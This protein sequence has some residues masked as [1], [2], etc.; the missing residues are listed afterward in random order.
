[1]SR[2][3][4]I[5]APVSLYTGKARAYLRF[6]KIPFDEVLA[7]RA[8]YQHVIVPRTGVRF[9]PVLITDDDIAVQDT[10]EIIDTLERRYPTPSIYPTSPLQRLVALLLE[11][12]G[13]EWLVIPA[14]HYRWNI[15]EN[16]E[17]SIEEFGRTSAPHARREQQL[18]IGQRISKPFAGALP[19]LGITE[20]SAPAIE[21]SYEA[22]LRD[23]D[24]H[25]EQHPFLLG[26]RPSIGDYGLIGPLHA[27]L[28]RD[29]ASGALMQRIA[30]R[31]AEW[32]GRVHEPEGEPGD[33]L[34]DDRVP[35]TLLPILERMFREQGPVL[36][37]TA[38]QL[39]EW[40]KS[41]SDEKVPRGIGTLEME[42]EGVRE[43]RATMPYVLWMWQR[44]YDHL[45]SL[46]PEAR[47]RVG[48]WL[49]RIPGAREALERP[50]KVRVRREKNR[51]CI[52]PRG[53]G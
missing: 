4:L 47:Q 52:D 35:E 38:A 51:L 18:E 37:E 11:V 28:W 10:T 20:R 34:P 36:L 29:P 8:V 3:R 12:Y 49:Q 2:H 30:P 23:F 19:F 5:G 14:M 17:F 9:I 27:H 32:V 7:T 46:E 48:S 16:R 44:P 31:V 26:S 15:A 45:S 40:A 53:R 43:Q 39:A 6:K 41:Q 21:K 24:R 50:L 42:I 33:F 22:F 25:L 1:M 13:D